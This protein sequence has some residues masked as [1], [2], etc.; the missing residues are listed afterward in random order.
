MSYKSEIR[1]LKL[2]FCIEPCHEDTRGVEVQLH[3]FLIL[4][5]D[6]GKW[7]AP[8]S[9]HSST[10]ERLPCIPWLHPTD[11]LD[12]IMSKNSVPAGDQTPIIGSSSP[13][14]NHH[15]MG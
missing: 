14:N 15:T 6:E 2:F 8:L 11:G 3:A 7:L 13:R 12:K 9:G 10:V 4:A 1:E 5:L